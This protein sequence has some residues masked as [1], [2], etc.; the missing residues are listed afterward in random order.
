MKNKEKRSLVTKQEP[1]KNK[2]VKTKEEVK[3]KDYI[4][5]FK[6]ISEMGF[7]LIVPLVGG[8]FLGSYLDHR[9]GFQPKLTLSFI[10][11]GLIIGII[12][13]VKIVSDSSKY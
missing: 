7:S 8:A 10:F 11:I 4:T 6:I 9:L 3:Y 12:A 2:T 13:M 5:G 1:D